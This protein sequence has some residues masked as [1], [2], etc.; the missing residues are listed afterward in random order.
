ELG[1]IESALL[2][3]PDVKEAVVVVHGSSEIDKR[4]VAYLVTGES[5]PPT[6]SKLRLFLTTKLPDNMVPSDY[7]FLDRLPVN[8]NGKLNRQALPAP[9][10]ARL[11]SSVRYAVPRNEYEVVIADIWKQ[12]L[13]LEDISI[14]ENFFDLG[15]HSL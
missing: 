13:Q 5:H 8:S 10:N 12:V 3:H 2:Q 1:E 15:G 7:V 11:Q 6:V 9:G 4:L 14:E